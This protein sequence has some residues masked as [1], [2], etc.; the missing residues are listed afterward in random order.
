MQGP[1]GDT[2]DH[3]RLVERCRTRLE[4]VGLRV[5]GTAA[6]SCE[7]HDKALVRETVITHAITHATGVGSS[8]PWRKRW[9]SFSFLWGDP[10]VSGSLAKRASL[11]FLSEATIERS[12]IRTP[13]YSSVQDATA[14][15][16][17]KEPMP[18]VQARK[19]IVMSTTYVIA[20]ISK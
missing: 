14:Y 10:D 5:Q 15:N 9:E 12:E 8:Q 3:E 2:V 20:V 19:N 6:V 7:S 1:V 17:T 18:E 13:P 4:R 11:V 16:S